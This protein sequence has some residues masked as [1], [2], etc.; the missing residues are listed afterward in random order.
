[1]STTPEAA[2]PV[3]SVHQM[4]EI[5]VARGG[6]GPP[7]PPSPAREPATGRQHESHAWPGRVREPHARTR[8]GRANHAPHRP[9]PG[10]TPEPASAP[11]PTPERASAPRP[12]AAS[13]SATSESPFQGHCILRQS[14]VKC[15]AE[16]GAVAASPCRYTCARDWISH[17][18]TR[19]R[20]PN[21]ACAADRRP[22][23]H[24]PPVRGPD[25]AAARV[26]AVHEGVRECARERPVAS[27]DGRADV[28][29]RTAR[30][31][32]GALHR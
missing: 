7:T 30:A 27:L 18:D 8:P 22:T 3:A 16:L 10:P 31:A 4:H 1:M 12:E 5:D 19:R 17:K 26:A 9:P 6:Q 29:R 32:R 2:V 11:G 14:R 24:G 13:T 25:A 20:R 15:F 21:G 28:L 23:P